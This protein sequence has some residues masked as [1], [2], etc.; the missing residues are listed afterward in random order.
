MPLNLNIVF[1]PSGISK[2]DRHGRGAL[3]LCITI[4]G[5]RAYVHSG[6][7]CKPGEWNKEKQRVKGNATA[8]AAFTILKTKAGQIYNELLKT[9]TPTAKAIK[10]AMEAKPKAD[11]LQWAQQHVKGR[12][13]LEASTKRKY[14]TLFNQLEAFE[15]PLPFTSP[16]H[17]TRRGFY[18]YCKCLYLERK[19]THQ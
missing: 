13:N 9:T 4:G 11:F 15:N 19:T 1:N 10:E 12:T 2:L 14:K 8:N 6:Y 18:F 7:K 3:K 17:T 5:Q 16:T